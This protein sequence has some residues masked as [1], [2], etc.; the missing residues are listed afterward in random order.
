MPVLLF[1]VRLHVQGLCDVIEWLNLFRKVTCLSVGQLTPR[2]QRKFVWKLC[3]AHTDARHI[4]S[5]DF[6]WLQS[7]QKP[8]FCQLFQS[9]RNSVAAGEIPVPTSP[10]DS[11]TNVLLRCPLRECFEIVRQR[12]LV[13]LLCCYIA[14]GK[15]K[16]RGWP[17]EW[18]LRPKQSR[19]RRNFTCFSRNV[20]FPGGVAVHE[21]IQ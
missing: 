1:H 2:R 4:W 3:E 10:G 9:H 8:S 17:P 13:N 21:G 20:K 16:I 11:I 12:S 18:K 14:T 19:E 15:S 7:G 5:L 6:C